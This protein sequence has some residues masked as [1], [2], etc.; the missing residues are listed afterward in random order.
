MRMLRPLGL[1]TALLL[2][3]G[4]WAGELVV[5]VSARSPLSALRAEQ[6]AGIFLGETARFPDG[7]EA[8]ALDQAPGSAQRDEFYLKIANRGPALMKAYWTK[9]I[10][11]GRGHPPRE[12]PGNAAVRKLVAE[13]PGM[14]G[15]I[16][17]SALDT[18][19][20]PVLVVN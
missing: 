7:S 20:K 11:T 19:V 12:L 3:G 9:R 4:A 5:I 16:E 8:V 10:F 14:I 1:L 17:R 15:Y 18:S 2:G 6:V 13:N